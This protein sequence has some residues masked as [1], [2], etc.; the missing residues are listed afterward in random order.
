MRSGY[1]WR[2]KLEPWQMIYV[3]T[4]YCH[5]EI[6]EFEN[7]LEERPSVNYSELHKVQQVQLLL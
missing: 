5:S 3:R 7:I 2:I 6:I 4:Q 1:F